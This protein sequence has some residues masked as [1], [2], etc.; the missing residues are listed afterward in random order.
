MKTFLLSALVLSLGMS[1]VARDD[2]PAPAPVADA[3]Q[4]TQ[5][6]PQTRTIE[7]VGLNGRTTIVINDARPAPSQQGHLCPAGL[8][9]RLPA[10][11]RAV[12]AGLSSAI[13]L[14]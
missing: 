9:F 4:N 3:N 11:G 14:P 10:G 13:N 12:R 7:I 6:A 1:A 8:R 2:S 5:P